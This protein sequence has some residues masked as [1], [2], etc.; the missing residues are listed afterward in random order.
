MGELHVDMLIMNCLIA[1]KAW[2]SL[3]TLSKVLRFMDMG[4]YIQQ[5][6]KKMEKT[7]QQ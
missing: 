3:P 2:P 6:Y 4:K 1:T 5:T 7:K